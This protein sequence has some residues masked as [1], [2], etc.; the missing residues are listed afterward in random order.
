MPA[1]PGDVG[2]PSS[3]ISGTSLIVLMLLS[4]PPLVLLKYPGRFASSCETTLYGSLLMR[5][6]FLSCS[7]CFAS[8]LEC[9]AKASRGDNAGGTSPAR[10]DGKSIW[11]GK[12]GFWG[13]SE[14]LSSSR[15]RFPGR[16]PIL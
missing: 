9:I 6:P 13:V 15:L 10:G 4:L 16:G 14:R 1:L 3:N 5:R 2:L 11:K 7:N 12:R 8:I